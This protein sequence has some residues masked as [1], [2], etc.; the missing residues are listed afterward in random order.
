MSATLLSGQEAGLRQSA[1]RPLGDLLADIN[2]LEG[3]LF[4]NGP[5]LTFEVAS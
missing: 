1:P 4:G 3:R 2:R 5:T